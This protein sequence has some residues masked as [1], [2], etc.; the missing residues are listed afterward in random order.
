M[1]NAFLQAQKT[2]KIQDK[3]SFCYKL[4]YVRIYPKLISKSRKYVQ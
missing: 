4:P 1:K 3:K 2:E